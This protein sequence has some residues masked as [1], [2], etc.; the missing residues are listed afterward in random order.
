MKNVLIRANLAGTFYG[1]L[2]STAPIGANTWVDLHNARRIWS[3]ASGALC[4]AHI[5]AKG[6]PADPNHRISPQVDV[7][8]L[9]ASDIIEIDSLSPEAAASLD[10]IPDWS[11]DR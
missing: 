4:C 9:R 11:A 6:L 3:W 1:T 7:V 2:P 5:A 10:A 8:T